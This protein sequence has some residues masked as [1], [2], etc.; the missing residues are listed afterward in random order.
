MKIGTKIKVA[1]QFATQYDYAECVGHTYTIYS[2]PYEASGN[3]FIRII[4]D[5][6]KFWFIRTED[7]I[8]LFGPEHIGKAVKR[9]DGVTGIVYSIDMTTDYLSQLCVRWEDDHGEKYYSLDGRYLPKSDVTV[10]LDEDQDY[11]P[12]VN[13]LIG[14]EFNIKY[15][16]VEVNDSDYPIVA[17]M[18]GLDGEVQGSEESF[19][20]DGCFLIGRTPVVNFPSIPWDQCL[21]ANYA[22]MDKN[23]KWYF[24][25]H[26]PFLD[27]K[28]WKKQSG[29]FSVFAPFEYSK[30][31]NWQTSLIQRP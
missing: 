27:E 22:A 20:S 23:G 13:P 8:F 14:Y 17:R 3:T 1:G 18:V 21:W 16:V 28:D 6:G 26:E 9:W 12:Q 19:T 25:S 2:E 10:F 7:A 30:A 15:R 29:Q 31:L 4:S 24:Y 11:P 5:A